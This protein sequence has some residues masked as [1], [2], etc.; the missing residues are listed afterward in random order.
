MLRK[1]EIPKTPR[2][3]LAREKAYKVLV[4]INADR[5]PVSID[6]II[7]RYPN[8][9]KYPYTKYKEQFGVPDHLDFDKRNALID[10]ENEAEPD[11]SKW[12]EHL[13]AV[14]IKVR[15]EIE[16]LIIFDDRVSNK[17]RI[18]WSIGHEF[19]HIFC[20]HLWTLS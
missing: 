20:G 3:S 16:Y 15:G 1:N 8:I 17:Q 10:K 9:E 11:P 19:G 2:F 14:V 18:R 6:A 4:D 7:D 13:E 12:R 5:L